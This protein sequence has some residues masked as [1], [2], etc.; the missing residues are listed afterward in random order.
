MQNHNGLLTRTGTR[1]M[2]LFAVV[3]ATAGLMLAGGATPA[4]AVDG[5]TY[6]FASATLSVTEGNGI[7]V[8]VVRSGFTPASNVCYTRT[9]GTAPATDYSPSSGALPFPGSNTAQSFPVTAINDP[10]GPAV[11][12]GSRT[13]IYTLSLPCL[14][15]TGTIVAPAS[16]TITINDDET[17]PFVASIS[18]NNG[19]I[20]GGT[21]LTITGNGLTGGVVSV[22]GSACTVTI[23]GA[24]QIVCTTTSHLVGFAD[25]I[26]TVG[27]VPSPNT[28][29][30]DFTYT[31]SGTPTVSLL[32]PA[33]CSPS[34][35]SAIT[36]T[37][38]GFVLGAGFTTVAFGALPG[39]FVNV[40]SATTLTVFCPAQTGTVNVIV[41]TASGPSINTP[42]DDFT[43][44]GTAT[45]TSV[46]PP[47]GSTAGGQLVT[48]Y[49]TN[50][51]GATNVLFGF[52]P[53][54]GIAVAFGGGSLTVTTP[55]SLAGT[56][57]VTVNTP[58]G[59]PVLASAYTFTSGTLPTITL[60][61]PS[62]GPIAG[63]NFITITGTNL[64]GASLVTFGSATAFPTSTS[65]TQVTVFAPG[66]STLAT[67]TVEVVVTTPVGSSSTIGTANDYLYTGA[68]TV[69]SLSV[70]TG[71]TSG[72]TFTVITG[73]GFT[74][75]SMTVAFGGTLAIFTYNSPTS[76]T[77]VSP[78]HSAG[79]VDVIVTTLAGS[80]PITTG[81]QFTYTGTS[82]PVVTGVSP[83]TGAIGSTVTLT[84]TGFIGTT[85]VTVGGVVASFTIVS[86]TSLTV[87]IPA[88]TP[89][90]VVDIRVTNATGQSTNVAADNFTNTTASGVTVTYTLYFRWS[91]ISW[92][93]IDNISASNA[94]KGIE[95]GAANPATN[96]VSGSVTAVWYFDG[97]S[98]TFKGYFVGFDNTPG[99]NDF[100]TLRRGT[101]YWIAIQ[102]SGSVTWT[103]LLGP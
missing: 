43:Y 50:L 41:T 80:S 72:S 5:G 103:V 73:T 82:I 48:I 32:S 78:A 42:A 85:S 75:S 8:G 44:G 6:S 97:P 24:T 99:A 11:N 61:S 65:A 31:G 29:S 59:N 76:I 92:N 47:S 34:G 60:L 79:L 30:D 57:N 13:V 9:G 67:Q 56:Y 26:V 74:T 58:S 101:S 12:T 39:T 88:G 23:P 68:P 25:V 55:P 87:V 28:A 27:S 96:D 36:V 20:A 19:P 17:G 81:D 33:T 38:T 70:T 54:T 45:I 52:A 1:L 51:T 100:T 91:L 71:P 89:N 98:Q 21:S 16:V 22:G 14:G 83:A 95:T 64:S 2:A 40:S 63:G 37:G 49:G 3:I 84:G 18:P 35:G 93:G 94:L 77:A 7:T 86:D 15:D 46:A 69:T 66:S 102:T 4:R 90:G 62:F 10:T 53:G